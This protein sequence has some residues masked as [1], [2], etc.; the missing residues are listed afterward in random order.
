[1]SG[2]TQ[3]QKQT[4][5]SDDELLPLVTSLKASYP[6]LGIAKLLAQ[7]KIDHPTISVSEKRLRKVLAQTQA[8]APEVNGDGKVAEAGGAQSKDG[9]KD[10]IADTGLDTTIDWSI[11]PKIKV[12][13]FKDGKG[14]GLVAREKL[15][16]GEAIWSEDPWITTTSPYVVSLT[17]YTHQRDRRAKMPDLF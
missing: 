13:M 8:P 11:A 12:K 4:V 10:L 7:L 14:K 6:D 15:L 17:S 9:S 5:P 16:E 3:V 2:E 1:M